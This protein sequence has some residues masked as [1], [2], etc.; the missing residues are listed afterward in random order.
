MRD[1]SDEQLYEALK[2]YWGYGEFRGTQLET[3]RSVLA[4][5]DTLA[6]MHTGAGK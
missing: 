4:G 2:G 5:R 3:I 1:I 6:L